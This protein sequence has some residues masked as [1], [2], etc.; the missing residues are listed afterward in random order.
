MIRRRRPDIIP[1]TPSMVTA[2]LTGGVPVNGPEIDR[3]TGPDAGPTIARDVRATCPH[4]M[5]RTT[6]DPPAD[7]CRSRCALR[8]KYQRLVCYLAEHGTLGDFAL[9]QYPGDYGLIGAPII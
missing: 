6:T 7:R 1:P 2:R 3:D 8:A 5:H 4:P 9:P